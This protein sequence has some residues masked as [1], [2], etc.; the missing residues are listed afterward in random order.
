[1]I[2]TNHIKIVQVCQ[3]IMFQFSC[4]TKTIISDY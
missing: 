4:C 2:V 1:L 3:L